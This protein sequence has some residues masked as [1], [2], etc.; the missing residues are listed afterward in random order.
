VLL[1]RTG[2]G[3]PEEAQHVGH[4]LREIGGFGSVAKNSYLLDSAAEVRLWRIQVSN[5]TVYSRIIEGVVIAF[6][7]LALLLIL[8]TTLIGGESFFPK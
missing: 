5:K 1:T 2:R 8:K 7:I 3:A 4:Q 6:L